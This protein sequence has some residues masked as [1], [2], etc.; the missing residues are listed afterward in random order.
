M[1]AEAIYYKTALELADL[2]DRSEI[3][4]LEI[5]ESIFE[6]VRQTE[7][8]LGSFIAF[9][10]NDARRQAEASDRRR[11]AGN[12]RSR[13][14]GIPV[15]IKDII[16]VKGQPLTC[17]SRMLEN[18]I[19]PYDSTVAEHLKNAGCIL[20][21]RLNMDEFAMGSSTETS[22][23]HCT[24]NP[25][26]LAYVPGGSSGGSAASVAA[27][28]SILA[29]GTDTGGSVRQ[30]SAFCG[31]VG[32][33]PTYGRVSRYG[34]VAF[35]S[36]LDQVGPMGRSV[37]D[38]AALLKV[39]AGHDSR[40]STSVDLPVDEYLE[41]MAI[42]RRWR[43]GVP[44]EFLSDGLDPEVHLAV[45]KAVAFYEGAG[46]EVVPV[47][48][49][50]ADLGIAVYYIIATAEASS[51]LAR[52]DGVRYGHRAKDAQNMFELYCKSRGEGFGEE[53]KRRII[54]GASVLSSSHHEA[55]YTRAQKV[56]TLLRQEYLEALKS[57]DVLI[58]PTTPS[59]AFKIGTK[60]ACPLQMYLNDIFTVSVNLTGLPGISLPCG[61]SSEGLPI[62]LQLIGKPFGEGE[63]LAIA[64]QFEGAH[65][66]ASLHPQL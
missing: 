22:T 50:H 43:L 14:D 65:E 30:P 16:A 40:D 57:V 54:L 44:Q 2:L 20:W 17:A 58:C 11:S 18:F 53:V 6:R 42:S 49:P 52:F 35:A 3:S 13:L 48:I 29:I 46:C 60:V 10:E 5:M 25:W 63:M 26:N 66:F 51:N 27:G 12:P 28:Q 41:E 55:Y 4:S 9:D 45:R 32:L 21:G 39:L 19:S 34:V 47:S 59:P 36:S 8:R 7:D 38:V 24:A 33:K 61:F 64:R 62:G 37:G 23:F 31:I 1:M 15:G 56:R